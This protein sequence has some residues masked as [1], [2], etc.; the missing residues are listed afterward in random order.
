M[1]EDFENHFE[2][3]QFCWQ[4]T[5][6]RSATT[7]RCGEI[8]FKPTLYFP[9]FIFIYIFIT[10]FI[11]FNLFNYSFCFSSPKAFG[12]SCFL[13]ISAGCRSPTP[14]SFLPCRHPHRIL[15]QPHRILDFLLGC[16]P[17]TCLHK[18]FPLLQFKN[19]NHNSH[20]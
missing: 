7:T 9:I 5:T 8:Q 2:S 4:T 14:P 17:C 13:T 3:R 16:F 12:F 15:E 1:Y 20:H 18:D 6:Y 10:N 19:H 11:L